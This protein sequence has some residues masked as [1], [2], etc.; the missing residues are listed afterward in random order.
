MKFWKISLQLKNLPTKKKLL[1]KLKEK[2]PKNKRKSINKR[3]KREE[4]A[5]LFLLKPLKKVSHNHGSLSIEQINGFSFTIL[6]R[7]YLR[8]YIKN[9]FHLSF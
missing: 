1:S 4:M 8:N 6:V 2:E 9:S 7:F 5:H 3:N